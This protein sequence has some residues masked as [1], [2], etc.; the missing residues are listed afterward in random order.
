MLK[1]ADR[2]GRKKVLI[3]GLAIQII[4]VYLL[5]FAENK[6]AY[7]IILF[8]SGLII[9][10]NYIW[11]I[12]ATEFVPKR[13]QMLMGWICLTID[14]F[15]PVMS[16]SFYYML[17]GKNWKDILIIPLVMAPI[18]LIVHKNKKFDT[19]NSLI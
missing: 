7:Y 17:G 5:Y 15:V 8:A 18:A 13:L 11:Y 9:S 4:W 2:F 19:L 14:T 1:Q 3:F 10:K 6:Y 12:M 16:S